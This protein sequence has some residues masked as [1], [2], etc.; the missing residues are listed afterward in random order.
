MLH[1]TNAYVNGFNTVLEKMMR[2][3]MT[4][5]IHANWAPQG[6]H[7]GHFNAPSI[8]EVAILMVGY[9]HSKRDIILENRE[10]TGTLKYVSETHR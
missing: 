10:S 8:D 9:E 5:H 2:E 6:E 3:E 1:E 4:V 7:P